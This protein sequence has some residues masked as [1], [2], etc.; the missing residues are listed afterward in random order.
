MSHQ[1]ADVNKTLEV[2][3]DLVRKEENQKGINSPGY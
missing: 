2:A 1:D 3:C